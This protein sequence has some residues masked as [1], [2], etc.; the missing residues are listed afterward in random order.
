[1]YVICIRTLLH[2]FIA[3]CVYVATFTYPCNHKVG[4]GRPTDAQMT[5]FGTDAQL[6]GFGTDAQVMG[7]S[8]Q[9]IR[10]NLLTS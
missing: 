4:V 10:M 8:S 6:M 3:S 9:N 1:M 2:E 5:G 7:I